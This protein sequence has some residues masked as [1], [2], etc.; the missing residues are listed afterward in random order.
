MM[1]IHGIENFTSSARFEE[2]R[3][4]SHSDSKRLRRIDAT[5]VTRAS[6]NRLSSTKLEME[7]TESY[8]AVLYQKVLG[9]H[10]P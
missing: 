5:H 1:H 6:R 4:E 8:R 9:A 3:T 7:S 10:F 2:I